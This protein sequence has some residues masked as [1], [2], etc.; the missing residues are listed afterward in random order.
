M[1]DDGPYTYKLTVQRR[2]K[3]QQEIWQMQGKLKVRAELKGSIN[4]TS[5][6]ANICLLPNR[7]R[8]N[9]FRGEN[10]NAV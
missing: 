8:N 9:I 3:E 4:S 10:K 5:K 7:C 6:T 2:E 1:R